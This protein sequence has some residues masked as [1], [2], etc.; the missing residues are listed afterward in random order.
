ME[1][2]ELAGF[3]FCTADVTAIFT[4]VNVETIINDVIEFASEYWDQIN[5]YGLKLVDLHWMLATILQIP[6]SPL[7]AAYTNERD[8]N[9]IRNF[10]KADK[11]P[12]RPIVI[13]GKTLA[14]TFCK[15]RPFD[16]KQCVKSNPDTCEVCPMISKGVGCSKRGVV[17]EI[18]C[19]LCGEKYQGETDRPLNHRIKEHIRS[20]RNPQSYPNNALGHHL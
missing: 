10:I 1:P 7:I 3:K 20:C 5:T 6:F 17:Y 14:Q 12:I 13:P 19:N 9:R 8:S 15:S 4:N 11:M 2:G 16:Q 18:T